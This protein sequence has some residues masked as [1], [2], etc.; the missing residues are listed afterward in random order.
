MFR[1]TSTSKRS[2]GRDLGVKFCDGY[3][4]STRA[5][6]SDR[7]LEAARTSAAMIARI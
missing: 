6:R 7:R 5:E 1:R 4:V 3:G 2:T